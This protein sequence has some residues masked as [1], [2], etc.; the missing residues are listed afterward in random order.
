MSTDKHRAGAQRWLGTIAILVAALFGLRMTTSAEFRPSAGETARVGVIDLERVFDSSPQRVE[1]EASIQARDAEIRE[2]VET[3][4]KDLDRMK[5][6]LEL[7]KPGTDEYQRIQRDM[8]QRQADLRFL[9]DQYEHEMER[10]V[11]EARGEL[12]KEIEIVVQRVC[13]AEGYDVVLQKEFQIPKTAVS[14]QVA[15]FSRPQFD[16]TDRV[17]AAMPKE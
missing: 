2:E 1:M 8:V 9:A 3:K 11:L 6:E 14:W 5:G 13:D 17:I 15:F 16:I 7:V 4:K 10:R 12:I